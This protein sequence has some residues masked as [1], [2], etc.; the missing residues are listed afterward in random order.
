MVVIRYEDLSKVSKIA[1][2][3]DSH[4]SYN[5]VNWKNGI[6]LCEIHSSNGI[7]LAE[8]IEEFMEPDDLLRKFISITL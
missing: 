7:L 1:K 5:S 6:T 2:S 3:M 8:I 4:F